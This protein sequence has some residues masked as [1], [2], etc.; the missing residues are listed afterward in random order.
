MQ[1]DKQSELT[2]THH[3]LLNSWSPPSSWAEVFRDE[4]KAR[5]MPERREDGV[6]RKI[7]TAKQKARACF[8]T[9]DLQLVKSSILKHNCLRDQGLLVGLNPA[10]QVFLFPD[11]LLLCSSA[12]S[13]WQV[14]CQIPFQRKDTA[15]NYWDVPD[16][17]WNNC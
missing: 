8:L 6:R 15:D 14:T 12:F 17:G 2:A 11:L 3:H 9:V 7:P 5:S 13:C 16:S 10:D 1:R 4:V